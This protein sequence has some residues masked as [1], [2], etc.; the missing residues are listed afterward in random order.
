MEGPHK[1]DITNAYEY[2]KQESTSIADYESLN[3]KRPVSTEERTTAERVWNMVMAQIDNGVLGNRKGLTTEHGKVMGP[4]VSYDIVDGGRN[5]MLYA[6]ANDENGNMARK[7]DLF[8]IPN[9]QSGDDITTAFV[10]DLARRRGVATTADVITE[11]FNRQ[12]VDASASFPIGEYKPVN[13]DKNPNQI[14]KAER[15]RQLAL[16][17]RQQRA[18]GDEAELMDIAKERNASILRQRTARG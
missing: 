8:K 11:I 17:H 9:T 14:D 2:G 6:F 7:V 15:A 4:R 3:L 16:L 13:F 10:S 12:I 1:N 5:V 18:G